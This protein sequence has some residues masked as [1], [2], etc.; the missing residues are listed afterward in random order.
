MERH[1]EGR[2]VQTAYFKVDMREPYMGNTL[3]VGVKVTLRYRSEYKIEVVLIPEGE[4]IPHNM[5]PIPLEE[6]VQTFNH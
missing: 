3:V 4:R 5:Q 1:G 6:F 2:I